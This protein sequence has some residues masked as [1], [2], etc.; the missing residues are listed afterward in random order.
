MRKATIGA[1]TAATLLVAGGYYGLADALDVLPGPLTVAPATNELQ[2]FPSTTTATPSVQAA[3]GLSASAPVPQAEVLAGYAQTLAT[4]ELVGTASTAVAIIDVATGQTLVDHNASTALTPASSNKLLTAWASLSTLGADHRMTTSATFQDG[5]L[6]LVGGGDVLL[7]A[8]AG[9]PDAVVGHAGL[10]DLAR[11]AAAKL[12][13]QGVTSVKLALDDTLFTGATFSPDWEAGNEA[14][15]APIQ[16]LMIDVTSY[17]GTTAYP[18]DPAMEA[19]QAFATALTAAGISIEGD[20]TRSHVAEGTSVIASVDSAPLSEILAVSLKASDNTM[21]EVEGRVLAAATGHEASFA[22]AAQA[23]LER[24]K[25]D[26]FD[27]SDVTMLDCSGLARA[28]KVPARLLAQ[29]LARAAGDDGGTVGRSLITALPVAGLDGTLHDRFTEGA[30][31]GTVRAK[32]GSLDQTASLSG[33][34]VT[35]EGRLLA[36]S[37]IVDGFEA[38]GLYSA[39]VALDQDLVTPMADCGCRG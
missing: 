37:V 3:A 34:V 24:L 13:D 28:D 38:G 10:G 21:T 39:R 36:F 31:T 26:G 2:P 6:T 29:I 5:T 15:V 20:I 7:A 30:A 1:L 22:G 16:P 4:D 17:G 32:T 11:A 18:Q 25:A 14:W 19:A 35:R 33:T 8:D 12:A 9:D 27:V 23:V